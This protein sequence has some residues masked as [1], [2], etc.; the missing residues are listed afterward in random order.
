MNRHVD[1]RNP[2]L[3]PGQ[4]CAR[5]ELQR[6][7]SL[8]EI[9]AILY[10]LVHSPTG[11]RYIH[12]SRADSENSFGVAFKTIPRDGTGVAHILEHTVLCGS[13]RYPVRDP[14][15]SMIKRSLNTFMNAFTASDWTMYPFSTQNRRDFYNLMSV[16]LDAAFFPIIDDLS[17]KQEGHR[18]GYEDG[19]LVFKGVVYNEMKGAMSSPDQVMG[20]ALMTALYPDTTYRFNSGGDPA[21][22]PNLT[23]EQ[24]KAFH[25][26]HYHPSNA[27]FYS[28]GDLPL[29]DHLSFIDTQVLHHFD[30]INPGTNV[31]SQPRWAAPKP[32][33]QAYPVVAQE[34][35]AGQHQACLAWLMAPIEEAY[36][37]FVLA[38]LEQILLGN[39]ASP[40]RKTLLEAGIGTALS[41]GTGFDADN[42]DTMFAC[43]L[44]GIGVDDSPRVTTLVID[45]LTDLVESG[46]EN[47][48]IEAAIHQVEFH[49]REVT[50]T[51]YPYGLKLLLGMVGGWLHGADAVDRLRIDAHLKRLRQEMAGGRFFEDCIRRW[52]LENPHRVSFV[53]EPDHELDRKN[54][55]REAQ[56]LIEI[57]AGL[58]AEAKIRIHED[59]ER[60]EALQQNQ[61]EL[62]VLPTLTR[63][64]V[65]E[66]VPQVVPE[67]GPVAM[68]LSP[69][70]YLQPTS[71]I[72]YFTSLAGAGQLVSELLP[73]V[74]FFCYALPKIG[75]QRR[76]YVEMVRRINTHMGGLGFSAAARTPIGAAGQSL[77]LVFLGAKCLQRNVDQMFDIV[78]ELLSEADFSDQNRLG[79]LLA[80]YRAGLETA[81]IHTGHRLAISLAARHLSQSSALNETWSGVEQLQT[82]K[83]F[84]RDKSVELQRLSQQVRRIAAQLFYRQ[85]LKSALVGDEAGLADAQRGYDKML[86]RLT[87]DG[88]AGFGPPAVTMALTTPAIFEGW[89]TAT[90]VSF[91]AQ[92]FAAVPTDHPDAAALALLA[93]VMR[94]AYLHR[95]IR[96]RGGAYGGFALYNAESALFAMASYRDPHIVRTL[97]AFDGA[98]R[99]VCEGRFSAQDVDEAVLQVCAD[100]DKPYPPGEAAR[101]AYVRAV[102]GLD[103]E[104]RLNF[105]ARVLAASHETLTAVA[106]RYF[107]P[108]VNGPVAVI[109]GESQLEAANA[110]LT[111]RQFS[112]NR[113]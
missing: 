1:T 7:E 52:F 71:G 49:H 40:L 29:A 34:S 50:N 14:F 11:A 9:D 13:R 72:T 42:R 31:P 95:E 33:R 51:P 107:G 5:F 6:I 21:Q 100:I 15:F 102:I 68:A 80:E 75:T 60:L 73:L 98:R 88:D 36:D 103:D 53:L 108:A 113:I 46:I 89:H 81:V 44:K 24:L 26:R 104:L 8:D 38:L 22:I 41:D 105:K 54:R 39:P 58:D 59:E 84:N 91:V 69:A 64:D 65:P 10:E 110:R 63:A 20:R 25:Q 76:D 93:K 99:F 56:A 37:V 92:A 86:T 16:Y 2:D 32:Y 12:I 47:E 17:F 82:I 94:S 62:S 43:G 96:E 35:N 90:A 57:A 18:L 83:S 87:A 30:K 78:A 97:S 85:G 101:K 111:E 23:Y 70:R 109:S 4:H 55:Q 19:Q 112:I 66:T 106:Q 67:N 48:L 79:T 27:F 74:P 28:Y 77:P 45:C 3:K 61:E